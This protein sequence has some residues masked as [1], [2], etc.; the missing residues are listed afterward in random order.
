MGWDEGGPSNCHTHEKKL[1]PL[2]TYNCAG[3]GRR[4]LRVLSCP[5]PACACRYDMRHDAKF[6]Y[7]EAVE[8][9]AAAAGLVERP[10]GAEC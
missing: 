5:L 10:P 1:C 6:A 2:P 3:G 9:L 4:R 8:R 7:Y